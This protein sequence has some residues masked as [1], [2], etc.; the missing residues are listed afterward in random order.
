MHVAHGLQRQIL[1]V[2]ADNVI[3]YAVVEFTLEPERVLARF[4]RRDL[5][6]PECRAMK[7]RLRVYVEILVVPRSAS[8]QG[9]ELVHLG[10]EQRPIMPCI[11]H[12]ISHLALPAISCGHELIWVKPHDYPSVRRLNR[13]G[14]PMILRWEKQAS[15]A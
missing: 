12:L 7:K 9:Q 8:V 15:D 3:P 4:V 10:E 1:L 13:F 5:V 11:D 2:L 14:H 6:V